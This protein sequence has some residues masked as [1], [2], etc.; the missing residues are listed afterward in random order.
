MQI[1]RAAAR[2]LHRHVGTD[3]RDGLANLHTLPSELRM[4]GSPAST[5]KASEPG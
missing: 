5:K 4:L 2:D 1:R 3:D